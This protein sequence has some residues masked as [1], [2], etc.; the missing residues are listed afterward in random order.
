MNAEQHNPQNETSD[1]NLEILEDNASSDFVYILDDG[2]QINASQI[3]F[4][5]EDPLIDLTVENLPFV[6]Y[7]D[8]GCTEFGTDNSTAETVNFNITGSPKKPKNPS[9]GRGFASTLPFKVLSNRAKNFESQINKY[10]ERT[11]KISPPVDTGSKSP[12]IVVEKESV[13]V[14]QENEPVTEESDISFTREQVLNMFKDSPVAANFSETNNNFNEKRRHVRKT[15]PT[16]SVPK[17]AE[18][19]Q[20]NPYIDVDMA[21][22][23]RAGGKNCFICDK[24]VQK[25]R[26]KLYIFDKEDQ[27]LHRSSNQLKQST[28]LKILCEKCLDANFKPGTLKSPDTCLDNDEYL[29]IRNNQQY[30]FKRTTETSGTENFV[31]DAKAIIDKVE[32]ELLK[33]GSQEKDVEFV[34]IEIGSDGQVINKSIDNKDDVVIIKEELD[35]AS[36]DVQMID[37]QPID[38]SVIDNIEE[39]DDEVKEFLGKCQDI[40]IVDMKCR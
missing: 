14:A 16:K 11:P 30:I 31:N 7:R 4:D 27:K 2:T 33:E 38:E 40:D 1:L 34:K 18:N 9:P 21:P 29:V 39:A 28:Q 3:H 20:T 6:K 19:S 15:D 23:N 32:T 24:N 13:P 22:G 26:D 12:E 5:N 17:K 35:E 36:S 8:D 37:Q 10:L 25:S